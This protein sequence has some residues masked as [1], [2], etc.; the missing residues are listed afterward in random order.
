MTVLL[1]PPA[2]ARDVPIR[3]GPIRANRA[4]PT[5]VI[6]QQVQIKGEDRDETARIGATPRAQ[7]IRQR[8][9]WRFARREKRS[10]GTRPKISCGARVLQSSSKRADSRRST[11]KR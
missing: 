6:T 4:R 2:K 5:N 1:G 8:P 9:A 11:Q 3:L 7:M 10:L